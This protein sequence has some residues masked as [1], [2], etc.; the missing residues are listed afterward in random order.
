[1]EEIFE[2]LPEIINAGA[3]SALGLISLAICSLSIVAVVYFRKETG[4]IKL[5]AFSLIILSLGTFLFFGHSSAFSVLTQNKDCL[6]ENLVSDDPKLQISLVKHND[7]NEDKVKNLLNHM[8]NDIKKNAPSFKYRGVRLRSTE[9]YDEPS[10]Y[11]KNTIATLKPAKFALLMESLDV[12]PI[13]AVKKQ[14]QIDPFYHASFISAKDS[15]IEN[16]IADRSKIKRIYVCA[17]TSVSGYIAPLNELHSLGIIDAINEKSIE[18]IGWELINVQSHDLV[19]QRVKEDND[20]IGATGLFVDTDP[21]KSDVTLV[22]QYGRFPQDVLV[23]SKDLSDYQTDI[24]NW[25]ENILL[26]ES[27]KMEILTNSSS[28]ISGFTRINSSLIKSYKDL[29]KLHENIK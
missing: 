5:I 9:Y 3:Q 27:C 16:L 8:I 20:A 12:I 15:G 21:R 23:I 24:Q 13:F 2:K 6:S 26:N 25:F 4:K 10:K 22:H 28:R 18:R 7:N 17:K 11:E 1:M 29:A 19:Y 14:N